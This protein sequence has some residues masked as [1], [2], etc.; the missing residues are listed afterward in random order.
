MAGVLSSY[1]RDLSSEN[2]DFHVEAND[3]FLE[4]NGYVGMRFSE[5]G[6]KLKQDIAGLSV[7]NAHANVKKKIP[8]VS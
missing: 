8:W 1:E 2:Y 7:Y 3:I 4:S 5:N 6:D